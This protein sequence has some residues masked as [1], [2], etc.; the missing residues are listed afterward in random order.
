MIIDERGLDMG[1]HP[2]NTDGGAAEF[3]ATNTY[4]GSELVRESIRQK[5]PIIYVAMNYRLNVSVMFVCFG[6]TRSVVK[7]ISLN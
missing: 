6:T 1:V 5:T 2:P 7:V 3:G 4:D